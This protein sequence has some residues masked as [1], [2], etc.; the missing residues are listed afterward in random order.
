MTANLGQ[1][2]QTKLRGKSDSFT[3]GKGGGAAGDRAGGGWSV[4]LLRHRVLHA[5]GGAALCLALSRGGA[6]SGNQVRLN[7][8]ATVRQVD[9]SS[10]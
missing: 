6:G 4:A 1:A 7:S 8:G 3:T 9:I 5:L 10:S 2:V